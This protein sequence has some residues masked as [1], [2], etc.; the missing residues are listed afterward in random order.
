MNTTSEL[1]QKQNT[2]LST[3]VNT[4]W[5]FDNLSY[6]DVR[7]P[8]L[9]LM[10]QMS[11]FVTDD[12]V[13]ARA[14]EIRESYEGRLMGSK[15]KP[16]SIV[17]FYF[18]KTW[19]VNKLVDGKYEFDKIEPRN[20]NEQREFGEV[21][22]ADGVTRKY[23][24]TVNVFCF[25]KG[26]PEIPYMISLKSASFTLGAKSFLNKLTLLR[27]QKKNPASIYFELGGKQIENDKGK[28]YA[29]TLNAAKGESGLD[30]ATTPEELAAAKKLYDTYKTHVDSFRIDMSDAQESESGDTSFDTTKF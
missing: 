12:K 13:N 7:L 15:D 14:G 1:A 25:V 20:E 11:A 16:V 18:N 3:E 17:P 4:D 28:F 27:A 29:F 22:G 26:N 8:K 23:Y 21:L 9:L 10:Q 24:K 19:T 6:E 5:G 30:I 2:T